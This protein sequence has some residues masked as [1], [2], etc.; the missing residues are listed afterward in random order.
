MKAIVRLNEGITD[1]GYC[2]QTLIF[3]NKKDMITYLNGNSVDDIYGNRQVIGY[4]DVPTSAEIIEEFD[5]DAFYLN[6]KLDR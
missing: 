6:D 5:L 1:D 2:E 3:S 4:Y